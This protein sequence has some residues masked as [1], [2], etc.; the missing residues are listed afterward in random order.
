M[1]PLPAA[2]RR[3]SPASHDRRSESPDCAPYRR[4]RDVHGKRR[5]EC[6]RHRLA[7]HGA[8]LRARSGHAENRGNELR[9]RSRC[10]YPGVRLAR[11]P[12]RRAHDFPHRDRHLRDRLAAVRRVELAGHLH[13]RPLRARRRRRDDGAGRADHHLPRGAQ[14]RL[15]PRDE[16]SERPRAARTGRRAAARRLHHHL[17]ALAPDLLHQC[18]DRHSRHLSD[19]PVYR[20]HARTGS[21][22]ARLDRFFSVGGRRGAASARTVAGRRRTHVESGR[23][24]H[25]RERRGSA[26][27][28]TSR[29]PSASNCRCSICASSRCRLSRRACSAARCFASASVR[30][31]FCCR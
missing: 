3:R 20:Q 22:T 13:P 7:R 9:A 12:F 16:L 23:V 14:V 25:V 28:S 30:C 5:C 29:T 19:Q 1:S 15:H 11:G 18:A 4:M 24:R 8:R 26:G 2:L 21:G 10:V 31:R 17:S 27:R 6:D